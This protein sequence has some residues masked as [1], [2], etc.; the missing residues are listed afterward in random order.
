MSSWEVLL[1]LL[2]PARGLGDSSGLPKRCSLSDRLPDEFGHLQDEIG[3]GIS[4]PGATTPDFSIHPRTHL[5][6]PDADDI[7]E[8]Q[9][10]RVFAQVDGRDDPLAS[11]GR[12][13]AT[14]AVILE[15]DGRIVIGLNHPVEVGCECVI[16]AAAGKIAGTEAS[17]DTTLDSTLSKIEVLALAPLLT[18][19]GDSP[20]LRVDEVHTI[21]DS[22]RICCLLCS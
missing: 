13:G 19:D 20:A 12:V 2:F 7:V 15:E 5:T 6:R 14:I 1:F 17:V 22:S 16:S 18:R 10:A 8:P 11:I 3:G 21:E 9:V 4:W